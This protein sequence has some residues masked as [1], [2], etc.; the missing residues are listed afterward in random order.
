MRPDASQLGGTRE[1][2]VVGSPRSGTTLV[3]GLLD[4][5]P[6]VWIGKETGFIP[7]LF[8]PGMES[9]HGWDTPRL[10]KTV[11]RVNAS[12]QSQAWMSLATV[13]GARQFWS[14]TGSPGYEGLI[15][16][17]WSLEVPSGRPRPAVVG[18][19]SPEYVLAIPLLEQLFP[20]AL[21]LH[22]VRDPRDVVSSVLP[23]HFG[24]HSAA[25]AALYWNESVAGWWAAERRVPASRRFEVRYEDLVAE[26]VA[27]FK[28]MAGF[29]GIT[30][31][32]PIERQELS[33][34]AHGLA[35]QWPHHARL[36]EPI[37]D[38]SVGRHRRDL[39][40]RDRALVEAIC[41]TGL[42]T[43]GYEAGPFRPSPVLE[44]KALLLT[45][46]RL[47]DVCGRA[48]GAARRLWRS[49]A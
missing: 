27:V 32:G 2:F 30:P 15:R 11:A 29:L 34:D 25:I 35:R 14:E 42:V 13:A 31:R 12:L 41:Y 28:A 44:E 18:D 43:Y 22:V 20:R 16:Y 19:Q 36:A 1:L 9:L 7:R 46:E 33:G 40:D 37:D 38:R 10:E 49:R 47:R 8:E 24:A 26:P 23:L 4:L 5:L 21:Y 6:G 48:L 39:S 17:V 3:A 45:G